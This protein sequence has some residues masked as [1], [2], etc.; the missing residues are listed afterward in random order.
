MEG[1]TRFKMSVR[2]VRVFTEAKTS[3]LTF[4]R[5]PEHYHLGT[6]YKMWPVVKHSCAH[7]RDIHRSSPVSRDKVSISDFSP[8]LT[9]LIA[10]KQLLLVFSSVYPAWG[11]LLVVRLHHRQ[12]LVSSYYRLVQSLGY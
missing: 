3:E 11:V 12:L 5:D 8:L 2:D 6:S 9:Y 4:R 10:R 7:K 1:L